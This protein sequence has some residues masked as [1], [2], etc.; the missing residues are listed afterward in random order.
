MDR[1]TGTTM[2]KKV[3]GRP[4]VAQRSPTTADAAAGTRALTA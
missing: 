4:D 1:E 3:N 2:N